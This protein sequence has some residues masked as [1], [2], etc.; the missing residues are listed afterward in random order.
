MAEKKEKQAKSV[1]DLLMEELSKEATP[2]AE[3]DSIEVGVPI[4]NWIIPRIPLARITTVYGPESSGKTTFCLHMAAAVQNK[5]GRV[6]WVDAENS[7]SPEYAKSIGVDL[8]PDKILVMKGDISLE[9]VFENIE[10]ILKAYASGEEENPA[11]IVWDSVAATSS[12]AEQEASLQDK[13]VA[14]NA[15]V[16]SQGLRKISP[17]LTKEPKVGLIIVTQVRST[18]NIS[19]GSIDYDMYGGRALKHFQSL[20][21]EF[22]RRKVLAEENGVMSEIIVQKSKLNDIVFQ[23]RVRV[24]IRHGVGIE[25]GKTLLD[26][27]KEL[28]IVEQVGG[29]Y[30][31]SNLVPENLR[32]IGDKKNFR[33]D[34]LVEILKSEPYLEVIRSRFR[35]VNL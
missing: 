3:P 2:V 10:K 27:A 29:Y 17:Y 19:W 9:K 32:T 21:I 25:V 20:A 34:E 31:F 22:R 33:S 16:M 30:K 5:G 18:M 35:E 13:L 1:V 11:L 14:S 8:S 6:F 23:S 28:K 15:R 7:F 12:E 24:V 26:I 4:V